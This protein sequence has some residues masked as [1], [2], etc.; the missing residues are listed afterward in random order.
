MCRHL[1]RIARITLIHFNSSGPLVRRTSEACLNA[2]QAS[3][4]SA[5]MHD[6]KPIYYI[7]HSPYK[8]AIMSY[9]M[10][11]SSLGT[12][13]DL[14]HHFQTFLRSTSGTRLRHQLVTQ[15][16]TSPLE[17]YGNVF[18]VYLLHSYGKFGCTYTGTLSLCYKYIYMFS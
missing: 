2:P 4:Q 5:Q 13:L 10:C 16:V 12:C 18:V 6:T 1:P 17:K 14:F 8:Y 9:N 15:S 3:L 7:V 11:H